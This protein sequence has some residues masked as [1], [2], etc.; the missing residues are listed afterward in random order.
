MPHST[1]PLDS[2]G[3]RSLA[4]RNQGERSTKAFQKTIEDFREFAC[5]A[6][7]APPSLIAQA[8]EITTKNES[9]ST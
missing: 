9:S 7:F 3:A 6:P 1:N 5:I 4:L 8:H 2:G